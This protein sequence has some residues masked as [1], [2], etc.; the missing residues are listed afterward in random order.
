MTGKTD[1]GETDH[2]LLPLEQKV[3]STISRYGMLQPGDRVLVGVSGGADSTAL[4][5]CLR[6][7][8]PEAR[9]GLVAGHLN[10]QLRGA[11]ADE[12]ERFVG[13]LCTDLGLSLVSERTDVRG[14][15]ARRKLNLEDAARRA[16]YDF[17]RRTAARL[18]C[19]KIAVGHNLNDQAESVLIRFLRGSGPDGLSGIHPVLDNLVIRPLLECSRAEIEAYLHSRGRSHREDSSNMELKLRRNRVR[20]ELIPY[21]QEYFNP[22]L[23]EALARSAARA[24]DLAEYLDREAGAASEAIRK[25]AG[26]GCSVILAVRGLVG[27]PPAIRSGVI[28]RAVRECRGSLAGISD[29]HIR[30]VIRLAQSDRSGHSIDLPGG[31]VASLQF[32]ELILGN[33]DAGSGPGFC[34]RLPIPGSCVVREAR[35]EFLATRGGWP[36]R[37]PDRSMHAVLDADKL[38]PSLLIR[39]RRAGDRYGG[40]GHRKVKG[41]LIDARIPLSMRDLQPM[42]VAGDAVVWIPGFLPAGH[43]RARPGSDRCVILEARLHASDPSGRHQPGRTSGFGG[44]PGRPSE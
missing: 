35:L 7:L 34:Y 44:I 27:L 39:S 38:P 40:P 10:H 16:R 32:D 8:A 13:A 24:R 41:M 9:L 21:L 6:G 31:L 29:L 23:L 11:E 37:E 26:P 43:F 28:R 33:R 36:A 4:L 20:H 18:D 14:L 19:R 3:R 2:R 42:V 30:E 12:D 17:L 22:R 5:V 15:A 25:A 1:T